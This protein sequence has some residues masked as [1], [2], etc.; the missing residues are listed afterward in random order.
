MR[1]VAGKLKG[2]RRLVFDYILAQAQRYISLREY[3]KSYLIKGVYQAKKIYRVLDARY[4]EDG[5]L[6]AADDIY[7]L[8]R[9]EITVLARGE[10]AGKP[11]EKIIASRR[12][13]YE[14]NLTVTLPQYSRGR[15]RPLA[16]DELAEERGA[17]FLEGIGVSP[18]R[19][20]GKARVI[21]DP[22]RHAELKPG[23][24]L[25]APVTDAAWTPLFVTAA[26]T[27]VDVGGPLSHGSI[28]AREFG[29]PCV[30]NAGGA[31]RLIE[32][33]QSIT[34]DG[35]KG[36]VYLHPTEK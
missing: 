36:K 21:T 5:L 16:P 15:P 19:V 20:T 32:T 24:I 25:V 14:R 4:R 31:T 28:V 9:P 34:V 6:R 30:V 2:P 7:F 29:M 22:R 10:G 33:G 35:G 27:V 18:G 8:T 12:D 13:E 26:A 17:E 11:M 3:M 23:E 1:E